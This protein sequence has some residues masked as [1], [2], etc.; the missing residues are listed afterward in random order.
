MSSISVSTSWLACVIVSTTLLF[1]MVPAVDAQE[2]PDSKSV[3]AATV[4]SNSESPSA[5]SKN[6]KVPAKATKVPTIEDFGWIA[7]H[8]QGKGMGQPFEETWN[9]PFGGTMMGMFKMVKEDDVSFYELLTIVK[10][11]DSFV[12]RLKHFDKQLVGWEEKDKSVEFPLV[13]VNS[14]EAVFDGLRFERVDDQSM[15]IIVKV[16]TG[17][18]AKEVTFAAKRVVKK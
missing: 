10:Q 13:R 2:A 11:G 3:A 15:N 1:W 5:K 12:L 14:K 9:P 16:G 6:S 7:G 17:G 4:K 8:W 18:K